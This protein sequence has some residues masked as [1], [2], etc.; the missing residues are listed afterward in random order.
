M[1]E[2]ART[3]IEIRAAH[4]ELLLAYALALTSCT[5]L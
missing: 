1:K 2:K 3:S 5:T 4:A